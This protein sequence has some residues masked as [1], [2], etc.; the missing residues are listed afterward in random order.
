MLKGR[1][2]TVCYLKAAFAKRLPW[3]KYY[4]ICAYRS[5]LRSLRKRALATWKES[6]SGRLLN[7]T[8]IDSAHL[9]RIDDMEKQAIVTAADKTLS[10]VFN[11][12]G[13]GDVVLAPIQWG[14]DFISGYNWPSGK[15]YRD[16]KQVDLTNNADV[17]IP[18][19]LSRSHFLLHLALAYQFTKEAKYA[20]KL[21]G[22]ISDWIEKNPL[23]YSINWGCAM[24][25]GIRAMNWMWAL[26]LLQGHGVEDP[27]ESK[28]KTSLYQHGWF[29]YRNLEGN[30]FEY[31]NNH[32]FSDIAGLL[33]LGL[34][35]KDDKEGSIWLDFATRE[36]YRELRLQILPCGVSFEG[37]TNYNRLMLELIM[38]CVVLLKRAGKRIPSDVESRVRTMYD[39]IYNL[40]M[41]NGQMPI[42]GDQDNGRG[43]P[44]GVE[45]LN[46]YAYLMSLGSSYFKQKRWSPARYNVYVAIFGELNR[47]EF[48][49]LPDEFLTKTSALYRDAGLAVIRS[50]NDFCLLNVDNQGFY[51]DDSLGS[52]HSHCDWLSFVLAMGGE[53]FIVDPGSYVY[54]SDPSERNRFRSTAMHNTIVVDGESQTIIPDKE[55]WKLPRTGRTNIKEWRVG[56]DVDYVEASHDGYSFL[57]SSVEHHRQASFDKKEET[58]SIIDNIMGA[59][60]HQVESLIHLAPGVGAELFGNSVRL[61][62]NGKVVNVIFSSKQD[63]IVSLKHDYV[64]SG[65]GEKQEAQVICIKSKVKNGFQLVTEIKMKRDEG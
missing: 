57:Q 38:P 17:K 10:N 54:S 46:D 43:L 41:P 50:A 59:G 11:I 40:M 48:D 2:K 6:L 25:V 60:E 39:F 29:L 35:F 23:M 30:I 47:D 56:A 14:K 58:L 36:F 44:W 13:S 33:H 8:K 3:R 5:I 26:S 63:I 4:H 65:Y 19:E 55:L 42:I 62:S 15:Y 34:L 51:M 20:D 7:L 9:C 12:L 28:I 53:T 61:E 32:Y 31:N 1:N 37:S 27:L 21:L 22:L 24:D 16:Y 64:S 45:D 49:S 18:R 52:G